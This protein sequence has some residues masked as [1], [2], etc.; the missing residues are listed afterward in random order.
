MKSK[1]FFITFEGIEGSGKTTQAKLLR[2]YLRSRNIRL[3]LTREPG[4]SEISEKIREILINPKNTEMEAKTECLLYAASRAQHVDQTILPAIADGKI[5]ISD[6]FADATLAYQGYG[7]KLPIEVLRQLN[8]FATGGLTPDLTLL[9]NLPAE[10]GLARARKRRHK[11]DRFEQEAIDFHRRVHDGY[12]EIARQFC[13]RIKI[14][15]ASDSIEVIHAKI[16]DC[17]LRFEQQHGHQCPR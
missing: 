6:R 17:V 12:L 2:D 16:K 4:G 9:L 1:G 8:K 5:I 7:R 10:I 3:L 14:I 13:G 11:L 15:D